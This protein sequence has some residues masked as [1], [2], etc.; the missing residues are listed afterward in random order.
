ML[1]KNRMTPD[2]ITISPELPIADTLEQMRN[3]KVHRYPV[4]D[5]KGKMVGIV[6]I[7]DIVKHRLEEL[8]DRIEGL[9]ERLAHTDDDTQRDGDHPADG[10][11][12][13]QAHQQQGR[14][15]Q[16]DEQSFEGFH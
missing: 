7:G 4:V 11:A 8:D 3:D 2:P 10:P 9:V 14:D 6:S 5:K 13:Q 15:E 16:N 1:V 12:A